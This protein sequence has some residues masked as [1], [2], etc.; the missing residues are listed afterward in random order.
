MSKIYMICYVLAIVS[1]ENVSCRMK[2]PFRKRLVNL[3]SQNQGHELL[4]NYQNVQY[5]GNIS[6][7][8]PPQ[9]FTVLFDLSSANLW[10]PSKNCVKTNLACLTHHKYD[11]SLS[12][13]YTP[14]G[15]NFTIFYGTGNITGYLSSDVVT[16][17]GITISNQTFAEAVTEPGVVFVDSLYDGILGLGFQILAVDGAVPPFYNM[18]NQQLIAQ[19]IFSIYLSKN[20]TE[21]FG[22]EIMF[23]GTDETKYNGTIRYIP[24]SQPGY[25]QFLMD[26]GYV[27]NMTFEFCNNSCQA[28][29]D[30]GT[31]LIVGPQ[32]DINLIYKV[33]GA[34]G[35]GFVNC[36]TVDSLPAVHFVLNGYDFLLNS[37]QYIQLSDMNGNTYCSVGFQGTTQQLWILGDLFLGNYYSVFDM[38]NKQ[39]GFALGGINKISSNSFIILLTLIL[40][41]LVWMKF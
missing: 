34:S 23:G 10:I 37:S 31:S 21:D 29:A 30:T 5:Y 40:S 39:I 11:S 6:I 7:G 17:A 14:N 20:K 16:I 36:S 8:T 18:I 15:R 13:T 33:L 38:G 19:P 22:G 35:Q 3:Q 2:I 4:T 12:K 27:G 41:N 25:W 26:Y 24:V 28:I 32:Q 9:N 1:L